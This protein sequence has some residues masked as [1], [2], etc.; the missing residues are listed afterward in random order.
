MKTEPNLTCKEIVESCGESESLSWKNIC[1][2]KVIDGC[3]SE[4]LVIVATIIKL[5]TLGGVLSSRVMREN[6]LASWAA[7][8]ARARS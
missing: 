6:F 5:N 1:N 7:R 3:E 2:R 8:I 4:L